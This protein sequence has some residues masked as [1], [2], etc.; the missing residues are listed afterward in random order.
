MKMAIQGIGVTA[1]FGCGIEAFRI[2]YNRAAYRKVIEPM[3]V[4]LPNLFQNGR[5]DGSTTFPE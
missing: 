5:C 1:G 4:G 2:A 3:S